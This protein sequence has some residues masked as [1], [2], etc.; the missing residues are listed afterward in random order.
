MFAKQ[1]VTEGIKPLDW[2]ETGGTAMVRMHEYNVNQLPITDG[3]RYVGILAMDQLL[4]LKHLNDPISSLQ[5]SL[6]RP[7]VLENA[8]LFEAMKAAVE[9]G[10]KVVPVLS[11]D[12]KYIGLITADSCMRYFATLYSVLEEGGIIELTVPTKDYQLSE[13]A[14]IAEDNG[15]K[16]VA[17]Y[18]QIDSATETMLITLK[19][20]TIELSPVIAAYE[21]YD[22]MVK[23]VYEDEEYEADSKDRYD[24]LMRY[25]D[26]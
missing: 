24:A 2:T 26:V 9:Y 18:T 22:Y 5:N 23:G 7:Y 21:R 19:V 25:L 15:V 20:N 8:H 16:I 3:E 10:V 1:I 4:A 17:C 14:H 13:I 6:K 12:E 11:D